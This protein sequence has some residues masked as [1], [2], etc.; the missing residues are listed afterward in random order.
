MPCILSKLR[1]APIGVPLENFPEFFN[2]ELIE[3]LSLE[4]YGRS[5]RQDTLAILR[6]W[7]LTRKCWFFRGGRVLVVDYYKDDYEKDHFVAIVALDYYGKLHLVQSIKHKCVCFERKHC[8]LR[9]LVLPVFC[10]T[11]GIPFMKPRSYKGKKPRCIDCRV[12]RVCVQIVY[13]YLNIDLAYPI[14]ECLEKI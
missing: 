10:M 5:P 8:L 14:I 2:E 3:L 12:R 1:K 9:R 7:I 4:T 13:K 11:C 6:T